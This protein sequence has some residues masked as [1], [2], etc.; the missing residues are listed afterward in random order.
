MDANEIKDY[1]DSVKWQFA[2]TMPKNPHE[3]TVR[4]W[5][6]DKEEKFVKFINYIRDIGEER[7]FYKKKYI[8]FDFEGYSYWTMGNPI[9]ET[10]VINRAK[11]E[12]KRQ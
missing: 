12:P 10:T 11:H 9:D 8:Y 4:K 3:Y 1:I 6:L 5:D 7:S 2:K